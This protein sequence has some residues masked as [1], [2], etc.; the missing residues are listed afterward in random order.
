MDER[1]HTKKKDGIK[2]T[3][4]VLS[5]HFPDLSRSYIKNVAQNP[6]TREDKF[7]QNLS[8]I[9]EADEDLDPKSA[10]DTALNWTKKPLTDPKEIAEHAHKGRKWEEE[11][12]LLNSDLSSDRITREEYHSKAR[13]VNEKYSG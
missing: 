13:A 9:L 11:M 3:I 4:D 10:I 7:Y 12:R 6:L 1:G 2:E 5:T 8:T